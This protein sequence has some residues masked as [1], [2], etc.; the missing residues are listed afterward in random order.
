MASSSSPGSAFA[1][2]AVIAA[3]KA[4]APASTIDPAAA[5]GAPAIGIGSIV[6]DRLTQQIGRVNRAIRQR[7]ETA[8]AAGGL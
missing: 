5:P 8:G 7:T 1:A 2:A 4:G 3:H 6:R